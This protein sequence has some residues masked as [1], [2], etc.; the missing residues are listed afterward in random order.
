[1]VQLKYYPSICLTGPRKNVKDIVQDSQYP[2]QYLNQTPS[3]L[4]LL[5][6]LLVDQPA[7]FC[8]LLLER[9]NEENM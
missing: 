4:R 8:P 7:Q 2:D 6:V 5:T 3:G 1:V 9:W